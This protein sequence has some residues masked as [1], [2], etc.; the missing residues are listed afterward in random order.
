[1]MRHNRKARQGA[2][3]VC[4]IACLVVASTLVGLAVHQ[5]GRCARRRHDA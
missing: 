4:V 3:L 5:H 1:M 2:V